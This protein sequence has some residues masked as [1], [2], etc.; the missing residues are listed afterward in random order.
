MIA[1]EGEALA[2]GLDEAPG[3]L[4]RRAKLFQQ[5]RAFLRPVSTIEPPPT[6]SIDEPP[7]VNMGRILKRENPIPVIQDARS[8]S[9]QI[10]L[11]IAIQNP[12]AWIFIFILAALLYILLGN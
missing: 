2:V 4:V 11:W 1:Q 10:N 12:V 5:V 6:D 8:H 3:R 7:P 9:P